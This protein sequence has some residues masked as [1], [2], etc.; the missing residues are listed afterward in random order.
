MSRANVFLQVMART[1]T[2]NERKAASLHEKESALAKKYIEYMSGAPGGTYEEVR[3]YYECWVTQAEMLGLAAP[4]CDEIMLQAQSG[5]YTAA[6]A[7]PEPRDRVL[8]RLLF[9]ALSLGHAH[10]VYFLTR[11][12]YPGCSQCL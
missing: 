7:I 10:A 9:V 4:T 11:D 1:Q 12:L 6:A 3:R 5:S 8:T 2:I